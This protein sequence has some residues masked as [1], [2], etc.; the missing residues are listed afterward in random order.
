MSQPRAAASRSRVAFIAFAV[1]RITGCPV[2]D[3]KN[4]PVTTIRADGAVNR[5]RGW[6]VRPLHLWRC[7]VTCSVGGVFNGNAFVRSHT[8]MDGLGH[9]SVKERHGAGKLFC[10]SA[11]LEALFEDGPDLHLPLWIRISF[12]LCVRRPPQNAFIVRIWIDQLTSHA[13]HRLVLMAPDRP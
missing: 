12:V 2:I 5:T 13:T 4:L 11:R 8:L 7:L 10:C 3:D 6:A 1:V 9:L